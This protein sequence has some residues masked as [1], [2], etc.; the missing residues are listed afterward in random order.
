M[1]PQE[2]VPPVPAKLQLLNS[3]MLSAVFLL[4]LVTVKSPV[5]AVCSQLVV[6]L[7]F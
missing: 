5:G 7:V 6:S 2:L 1:K 3:K 4:G